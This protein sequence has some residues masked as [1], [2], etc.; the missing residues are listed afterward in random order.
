MEIV[1]SMIMP[2]RRQICSGP[3]KR[4]GNKEQEDADD[5]ALLRKEYY[6]FSS[7]HL[8]TTRQKLQDAIKR[9]LNKNKDWEVMQFL[10][11]DRIASQYKARPRKTFPRRRTETRKLWNQIGLDLADFQAL[12]NVKGNQGNAWLLVCVELVSHWV[13][14]RPI[15]R[16][17]KVC[18]TEAVNSI[19]NTPPLQKD[20]VKLALTDY[21]QEF[22]C[23]KDSVFA[24]NGVKLMHVTSDKKSY[25]TER[26]IR[27]IKSLLY[28]LCDFAHSLAWTQFI[29]YVVTRLNNTKSRVLNNRTPMDIINDPK[30]RSQLKWENAQK[31]LKFYKTQSLTPVYLPNDKVRI[32][33]KKTT[34][35]KGHVAPYSDAL[36]T[37]A[38][39]Y[40]SVPLTFQLRDDRTGELLPHKFYPQE[41]SL[42]STP[43]IR[44]I[45]DLS[46]KDTKEKKSGEQ[47][48]SAQRRL[49][50]E[51][52]SLYIAGERLA[53]SRTLRSGRQTAPTQKEFELRDKN[54]PKF[55]RYIDQ[56]EKDQMVKDGILPNSSHI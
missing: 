5:E 56:K 22:L 43:Q 46:P 4:G 3:R 50:E 15:K 38:H 30:A 37:V 7:P 8:F 40:P 47:Q 52:K 24:A 12:R 16:K 33:L 39:I 36:Y 6:D 35:G 9:K 2:A 51:N 26:K 23:I 42:V 31:L 44:N 55:V 29:D 34:F 49:E 13:T 20:K 32:L 1:I 18:M 28:K 19:L 10:N 54:N 41:L 17:D 14:V 25:Q 48:T 53:Q 27:D 45:D 21:G 11:R